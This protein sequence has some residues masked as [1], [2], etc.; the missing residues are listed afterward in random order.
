MSSG[1]LQREAHFWGAELSPLNK[2]AGLSSRPADKL[3]WPY[4]IIF[5]TASLIFLP[6]TA[7]VQVQSRRNPALPRSVSEMKT[8]QR[9]TSNGNPR[10]NTV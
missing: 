10:A 9:R 3:N 8:E 7:K 2:V 1:T 5:R 6:K 4:L